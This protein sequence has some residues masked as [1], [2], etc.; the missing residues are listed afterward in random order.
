MMRVY[1][2]SAMESH[3][4]G[5]LTSWLDFKGIASVTED[6][7]TPTGVTVG[8]DWRSRWANWWG[9][10]PHS[11]LCLDDVWYKSSSVLTTWSSTPNCSLQKEKALQTGQLFLPWVQLVIRKQ[12]L[13][14]FPPSLYITLEQVV[15]VF[16]FVLV[17]LWPALPNL[18]FLTLI[19]MLC[20][21]SDT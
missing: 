2:S 5:R 9:R 18:T 6:N 4:K 12:H 16:F 21:V 13:L 17:F 15:F 20:R 7:S 14:S 19:S 3:W 8:W 1:I 11:P 10:I